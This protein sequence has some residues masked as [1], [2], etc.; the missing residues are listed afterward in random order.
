MSD[1]IPHLHGVADELCVI[2]SMNTDQFNHAPAELLLY[3]GSPRSGRPSMGAWVTYG[4]GHGER[5]P[6][7]LRRPD[8]Q[9]RP[10]QRRQ[11]LVRQRL[12]ARRSTRACSAARRATRSSTPPTP[13]GWTAPLRRASLDALR[14]L[15]EIQAR[16]LGHPETATRIAQYELAFRMQ[17]SVPE[18]MDITREPKSVARSLRGP[19]RRVELRQQLPA[20]PPAG[21]AGRPVRPALRL[22]LGLPRHRR[23]RGHPRRPDQEVRHDGPARRRPDQGPEAA[24]PARRDPDHLRR[25][26]RPDP[27]PRGPDRR[28]RPSSA[29]TTSPTAT[30]WSWPAAASSRASRTASPTSWA[31]RVARDKVH[32]HDLQATI[33]HLLGLDHKR[34]TYRFQGRDYRLTDVHGKVVREILA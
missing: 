24:R 19:A 15:N 3:T 34:L 10:A 23:R 28:R 9:R 14:D 2:R 33:L 31:S 8:L 30:R 32:V 27:V 26:V 20:R 12:P 13:P 6:A 11:E 16:E 4:L 18:V 1:A 7:R 21:R 17:T 22:G 25:R 5:E 29:A